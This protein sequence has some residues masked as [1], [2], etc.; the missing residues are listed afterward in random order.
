MEKRMLVPLET[1]SVGFL[2]GLVPIIA[3]MLLTQVGAA[4]VPALPVQAPQVQAAIDVRAVSSPNGRIKISL[5]LEEQLTYVVAFDGRQLLSPSPISMV[6]GDGTVL[7]REPKVVEVRKRA[8]DETIRPVVCQKR[9]VIKNRCNEMKLCFEGGH[10][11]VVRAYNDGVAYR[12]FTTFDK[13]IKVKFEQ[14]TFAFPADYK[15]YRTRTEDFHSSQERPYEYVKLSEFEPGSLAFG[16]CLVDV[17]D[18]PKIAITEADLSNYPGMWITRHQKEQTSLVGIFP[19]YPAKE[20]MD[21]DRN[22]RVTKRADFLAETQGTRSFPWRVLVI[23]EKDGQLIESDIVYRLGPELALE[24]TSWIKPGKVAWDWWNA[25]NI[26]NVDF[27]AGIN[28]A[29]YKHYVDFAARHGI[30]YIIL[31][32]GWSNTRDLLDINP[33]IN[34]NELI[35]YGNDKG[36]GIILWCV[37]YTLDQQLEKALSSFEQWGVKGVKVDFMDRDDQKMVQFYHR[38]SLATARHKLLL[39][40]HGAYKPTGLRRAYPNLITREGVMGLEYCKWSDDSGPEYAVTIPFIR[41]LAGPM[42]YTPGAMNNAQKKNFRS[43]FERPMSQGTRAHQLAMYVVFESPLQMLC[44]TPTAYEQN[45]QC[46]EFLS[47]VPTTW[48]ETR[49]LDAEVAEYAVVARKKGTQWYIGAITDWTPR[50]LSLELSFLG[51]G[52]YEA[53]IIADGPNA[54]RIGIDHKH[55]TRKVDAQTLLSLKLAAGGGWAARIVPAN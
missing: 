24:D 20:K 50:Q 18:G 11:I 46:L 31:D 49:V 8:I 43:I 2:T 54:G 45:P 33:N 4:P 29:T 21:E 5:G 30:E 10:G 16:P 44:D 51:P 7:G 35:R 17:P 36:V 39:D 15:V 27:E 19:A 26:Y 48:D 14:A 41:M 37:W 3:V 22:Q 40:L 13:P 52:N 38:V 34:L 25:L 53:H 9:S 55:S 1:F 6:F 23:A 47:Q 12:F 42:D 32:E 28:T